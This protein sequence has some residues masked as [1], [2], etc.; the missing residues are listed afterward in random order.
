MRLSCAAG[1][2]VV[3]LAV[4]GDAD[5]AIT[6]DVGALADLALDELNVINGS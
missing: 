1:C 3:E 5:G 6:R 2:D 4:D